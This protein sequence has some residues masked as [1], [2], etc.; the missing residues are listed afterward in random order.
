M[1]KQRLEELSDEYDWKGMFV[2]TKENGER[3]WE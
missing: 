1:I 3:W 2:S